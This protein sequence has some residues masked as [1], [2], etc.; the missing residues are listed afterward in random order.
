MSLPKA[1]QRK[2][3]AVQ[4][5]CGVNLLLRQA[6][7]VLAVAGAVAALA[8]LADRLASLRTLTAWGIWSFWSL[9]AIVILALWVLMLPTRMEAS[10]L[11]DERLKL[12]E[13]FSTTLAFAQ[14]DD[15]FAK[16]ARAESLRVME[17]AKLAGH[18][19]IML[20][21]SWAYGAGV[22][23]ATVAMVFLL[24]Q[25]DLFGFARDRQEE[26]KKAQA[27]QAAQTQVKK[28]V[29][30]AKAAVR[31]VGDPNLAAD[32]KKLDE[33]GHAA[34]PQEAK[35]EAIK[36]LGD[37][38]DRLQQMQAGGQAKTAEALQQMLKQLHGSTDPFS[39]QVRMALGKG[40]FAQ[41][42]KA[43]A[44]LQSQLNDGSLPEERRKELAAQMQSLA[45]EL[46]KLSQQKRQVEEELAKLG[47]DRRLA[48]ASP[49]QLRQAM[50]KQGLKPEMVEQLMK[51]VQASQ[52]ASASCA[53][54]GQ[55][56][57]M[58]AGAG[59]LSADGLA[60]A[61]GELDSL[62]A[63]QQQVIQLQATLTEL[64]GA[65][66]GLGQGMGQGDRWEVGEGGGYGGKGIGL[67]SVDEHRITSD[68]LAANKTAKAPSRP[69]SGPAVA[70]WYFKDA[71][72]KG[73]VQRTFAEVVQAGRDSAAEAISENQIPRRYEDAV[74]A[75]FNQ[76]E[77]SGPKP[78]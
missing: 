23:A 65:L 54:L 13:R 10:L 26:Q 18:F 51:K 45:A 76:L 67:S 53:S 70:S 33:L 8:V 43:L 5:R 59:G 77:E 24:P 40:D 14:S 55:A 71:Q 21:R 57:G 34:E 69:D 17:Q 47:L 16:A 7:R 46:E 78:Q 58:A 52:A 60:G 1:I 48:Q 44:Q 20:S 68:P 28:A 66:A 32:L 6:G 27:V 11:L 39:Q 74:K 36:A 56:L 31:A 62:D 25:Y 4:I 63:M 29:Q 64:S 22:W 12:S 2:V 75:Y 42:A 35:R 3:R 72:I 61:I 38:A 73:E 41:A 9:A 15:P 49:E 19:P 30:Q 50:Q 37:L